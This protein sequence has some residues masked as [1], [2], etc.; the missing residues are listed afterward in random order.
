MRAMTET[1]NTPNEMPDVPWWSQ[2]GATAVLP[3][4]EPTYEELRPEPNPRRV[5]NR[6]AMLLALALLAGGGAGGLVA[7]AVD[8]NGS[9]V[10]GSVISQTRVVGDTDK[11]I[12]GTPESAASVIS[13]SVVTVEVTGQS[14]NP[15]GGASSVSDTGSGI[16]IRSS[17]YILTNNHVVAAAAGGGAVHVTLQD[18]TTVAATIVGTDPTTDLAVLRISGI[19]GLHAATFADSSRLRVGQAVLAIGAPLGLANTV[20]QG[21]V[22][23]LQRPVS[24]G[25]STSQQAVIDAVQTDAAINPGNSGGALVD[26]AGR[27]VGINSA[28]ATTGSSSTGGQAGNIGVGFAIPSNAAVKV[29]DQLIATGKAT[30]SQMGVSVADAPNSTDGAPG[31][32]AAIQSVTAGGPAQKGG[33]KAGDIVTKVDDRRVTDA[34]SLIVAIRSHD[35]GQTVTL[36][37]TRGGSTVTVK[38]TLASASS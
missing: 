15:F 28:I 21:I 33:L 29:A 2:P 38:V 7:H 30:H 35:P 17:G 4:E 37:V 22:S 25:D 11:T 10:N 9:V 34:D 8:N 16:I 6:M 26:L 18:G 20:T 24:T 36:V 1:P 13:P 5:P 27:V 19:S 14:T 12:S 3:H 23:T 32:G 31:L